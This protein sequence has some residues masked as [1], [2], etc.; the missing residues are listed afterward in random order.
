MEELNKRD[1]KNMVD[2][3]VTNWAQESRLN[4]VFSKIL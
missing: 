3:M 1:L 4:R 2:W